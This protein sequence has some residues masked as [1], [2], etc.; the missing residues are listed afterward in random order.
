MTAANANVNQHYESAR[1]KLAGVKAGQAWIQELTDAHLLR[2]QSPIA[3][4][5]Y[6]ADNQEAK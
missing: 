1:E 3:K 2:T 5:P 4:Q 6:P